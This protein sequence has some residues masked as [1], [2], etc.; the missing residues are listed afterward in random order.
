MTISKAEYH[1]ALAAYSL[2][3]YIKRVQVMLVIL[4]E[5]PNGFVDEPTGRI[6][7]HEEIVRRFR[8]DLEELDGLPEEE[9]A[10][11]LSRIAQYRLDNPDWRNCDRA[12]EAA[13]G[14]GN[15]NVSPEHPDRRGGS[16]DPS[17][18]GP[19]AVGGGGG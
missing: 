5:N 1:A 8:Q 6:V 16:E 17:G 7:P 9:E 2:S 3:R 12:A 18:G 10:Q 11:L 4:D 13:E 15:S 19:G 14:G